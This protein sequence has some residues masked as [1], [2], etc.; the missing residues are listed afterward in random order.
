[1][2][3]KNYKA[4]IKTADAQDSL[5]DGVIILVT[6]C[7]TG[8]DNLRRGFIQTFFLAPQDNG[9]FVLNDVFRYLDENDPADA[10]TISISAI[11]D[12]PSASLTL[13]PG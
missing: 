2:D 10:N 13:D 12:T 4:E 3:Y 6:G 8:V 7:L 9:Y 1:M 11:N 5:K